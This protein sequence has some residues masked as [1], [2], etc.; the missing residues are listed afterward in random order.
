M[1]TIIHHFSR[2]NIRGKKMAYEIFYGGRSETFD[3]LVKARARAVRMIE[4]GK[5]LTSSGWKTTNIKEPTSK[6]V[7]IFSKNVHHPCGRVL[8]HKTGLAYIWET[9]NVFGY[10]GIQRYVGK[11]G[12]LIR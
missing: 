12:K 3:T 9:H 6:Y 7:P 2:T 10:T 11:D 1:D 8:L 4:N 5:Y